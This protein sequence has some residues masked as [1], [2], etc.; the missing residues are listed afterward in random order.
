MRFVNENFKN[1]YYKYKNKYYKL[2][3]KKKYIW[4]K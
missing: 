3:K 4:W 1:K 2:L